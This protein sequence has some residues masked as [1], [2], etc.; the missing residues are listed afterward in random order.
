MK[1]QQANA[2]ENW[3]YQR[4]IV[5]DPSSVLNRSWEGREE[6]KKIWRGK[7]KKKASRHCHR[8]H[9]IWHRHGPGYG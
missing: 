4:C 1:Q 9:H 7:R 6:R 3:Y 2:H 5:F 8:R